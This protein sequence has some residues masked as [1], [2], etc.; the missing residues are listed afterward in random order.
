M[1]PVRSLIVSLAAVFAFHAE[2]PAQT[3]LSREERLEIAA[4]V[5]KER[6]AQKEYFREDKLDPIRRRSVFEDGRDFITR[7]YITMYTVSAQ[8][9]FLNEEPDVTPEIA[10]K[11]YD[12]N[13][14]KYNARLADPNLSREEFKKLFSIY[15]VYANMGFSPVIA[16]DTGIKY[17]FDRHENKL[18]EWNLDLAEPEKRCTQLSELDQ[19]SDVAIR[20][21]RIVEKQRE[22]ERTRSAPQRQP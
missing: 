16:Y 14:F 4:E 8:V 11:E 6:E 12:D 9:R 3:Q 20:I 19:D 17:L 13:A 15:S 21:K 2:A 10:L 7:Q 1:S 18:C 22:Q 5:L